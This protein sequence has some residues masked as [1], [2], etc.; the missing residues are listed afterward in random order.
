MRHISVF[1]EAVTSIFL[2]QHDIHVLN[3]YGKDK[4]L[5][6]YSGYL[7]DAFGKLVRYQFNYKLTSINPE[8]N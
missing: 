4:S 8:R 6:L 7:N 2:I 1:L 3:W 5:Y